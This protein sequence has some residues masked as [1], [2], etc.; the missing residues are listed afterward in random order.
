MPRW[1][2][3]G[4]PAPGRNPMRRGEAT[5]S[6][7][8]PAGSSRERRSTKLTHAETIDAARQLLATE[9][10]DGFSMRK[11]AAE[12]DVNPM[13]IY[14]RFAN[15]EE[16]LRAVGAQ[17]LA[18]IELPARTGTWQEQALALAHIIRDRIR[19]DNAAAAALL[20]GAGA[21]TP[22]I[23]LHL[24]DWGLAIME[25]AGYWGAEATSAYRSLFWHAVAFG[26]ADDA[27]RG[28]RPTVTAYALEQLDV[29]AI[30]TFR[31]HA[32]EF[33]VLDSEAVFATTTRLLIDGLSRRLDHPGGGTTA[34]AP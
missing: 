25:S 32:G 6:P 4:L 9:G 21:A 5:M 15:R 34:G 22:V 16:L 31:A 7:D 29:D 2:P 10:P 11:L 14:L 18:E 3:S 28:V 26:L 23:V 27:L 30:P 19:S 13:T 12:L 33:A 20:Q 17:A 1:R 24:T 8:G